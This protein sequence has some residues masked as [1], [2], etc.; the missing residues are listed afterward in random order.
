MQQ[1]RRSPPAAASTQ[2]HGSGE[3]AEELCTTFAQHITNIAQA[4]RSA[5]ASIADFAMAGFTLESEFRLT[6]R[7]RNTVV[8]QNN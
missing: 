3:I 4:R 8:S 5:N 2:P 1:R 6:I 7:V